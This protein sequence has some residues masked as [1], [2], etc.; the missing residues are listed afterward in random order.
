M[1]SDNT[2]M[3]AGAI[4][5]AAS[6]LM[7]A[8]WLTGR[9]CSMTTVWLQ[10]VDH[11]NERSLHARPTPRTGGLAIWGGMAVGLVGSVLL[12][13][14]GM[15]SWPADW[16][17]QV[18]VGAWIAGMVVLVGLVS[19]LDDHKSVPA[20]ARLAIH[21]L[22]ASGVVAGAGLTV[23]SVSIPTVGA[24]PL[25][26]LAA[27]AT[28]LFIVWMANLYNFMDGMDGFA[29]GMTW[30][31]FGFLSGI[32]WIGSHTLIFLP[33]LLIS[34]AAAGFLFYNRPPAR[35]FMGDVGSVPIGFLAAS[36]VV[37]GVHD[38]IFDLWV[39]ALIFSPF[40][41]DATVT[42]LRRM[43]QGQ[44]FWRA[45]RE[46]YYQRL[47]LAGWSHRK[48]VGVEYVLMLASGITAVLYAHATEPIRL[49]ILSGWSAV[50]VILAWSVRLVERNAE[51]RRVAVL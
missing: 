7:A 51:G 1:V 31:G 28:V 14:A 8:A 30:L 22:A 37:Q 12:E 29:G 45:H 44:Q 4:V 17:I 25:G 19:F 47:V 26:W 41:V 3:S 20:G 9:L 15:R 13:R 18:E 50:Y 6:A 10:P 42:V 16:P 40:I 32:A 43:L 46:H 35:I 11:P 24:I 33:S 27:P 34:M 48:A 49:M 39:P 36:L 21:T 38:G 23:P 5:I 2:V